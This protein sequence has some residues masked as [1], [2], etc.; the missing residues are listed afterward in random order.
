M[1]N[2]VVRKSKHGGRRE[3]AGR[4]PF[5]GKMYNYKADKDLVPVLDERENRNRFINNAVREK[6]QREG[7]I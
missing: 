6:A 7:L 3:G 2:M 5:I 4:K 1:D